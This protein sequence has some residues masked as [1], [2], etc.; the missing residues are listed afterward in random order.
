LRVSCGKRK[1]YWGI[2]VVLP[3][4]QEVWYLSFEIWQVEDERLDGF[5]KCQD[6]ETTLGDYREW[7]LKVVTAEGQEVMVAWKE[8]RTLL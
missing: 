1:R 2:V 8:V 3:V 6:E 7:E 4:R 5:G